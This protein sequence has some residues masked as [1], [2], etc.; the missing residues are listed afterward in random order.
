MAITLKDISELPTG[1]PL[2]NSPI[3]FGIGTNIF[4]FTYSQLLAEAQGDFVTNLS[5]E[6]IDTFTEVLAEGDY[7]E[8]NVDVEILKGQITFIKIFVINQQGVFS[9]NTY[10][11][12]LSEGSYI[13]LGGSITFGDL[14][15]IE[16]KAMA[17][18]PSGANTVTYTVTDLTE[19]NESDPALDFTNIDLTY[20]VSLDGGL[21][22]FVGTNGLYGLGELQMVM[23]DLTQ[24]SNLVVQ[25]QP[26]TATPPVSGL[27]KVDL[28]N[29]FGVDYSETTTNLISI[30][31]SGSP[32]LGGNARIKGNW[33][34][35]PNIAGATEA[36]N[37]FFVENQVIYLYFESW[38]DGILYW[39]SKD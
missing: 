11:I 27:F 1:T 23:G 22:R 12:P 13:P 17:T 9:Q 31:P 30:E 39:Y 19:L 20:F 25:P 29:F 18:P 35:K 26:S 14:V 32:V 33:S 28:T 4:T 16:K 10:L 34:I 24:I 15:L 37:S 7:E 21:Y 6:V 2:E 38:S 3:M 5:Y 8:L 36:E